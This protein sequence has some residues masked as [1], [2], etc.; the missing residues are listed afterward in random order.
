MEWTLA[1][2]TAL[3]AVTDEKFRKAL[4]II[5]MSFILIL[6]MIPVLVSLP[7]LLISLPQTT[8]QSKAAAD[9]STQDY[10]NVIVEYK[11]KI[12]E[13][14]AD[15][16][17]VYNEKND[18][19][20]NEVKINYPSVAL[21]IAFDNVLNKDRI[22]EKE[23]KIVLD[24][25]KIFSFLD[26]CV[27][28]DIIGTTITSNIKPVEEI[29]R[30][31]FSSDEDINQFMSIYSMVKSTNLDSVVPEVKFSELEYLE[32]GSELPYISQY[33]DRWGD[34]P[35]GD[36]T[37]RESGCGIASMCMV[38]N[39]LVPASN[40][41]PPELANW[42]NSNGF[43]VSGAGTAWAIFPALADKYNLQMRNLSRDNPQEILSELS[44]GH[45]VVVSMSAGHF[46]TGGHFI[47]LCGVTADGK[48]K[49]NDP[50][51]I[52]NSKIE[53]DYSVILTESS[54]LSS[55]CFWSF[56]KK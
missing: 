46:T 18:I 19:K 23:I 43:Y 10:I 37:V 2:K 1:V 47:V 3:K 36:S 30:T 21:V 20:I 12:H 15:Q 55:S 56:S 16:K 44:K 52:K 53:W 4:I 29:A 33:N 39:G 40:I 48:I 34:A 49:V 22:K 45:A 50:A 24:K 11:H 14:L 28:Y 25:D 31:I 27:T 13:K 38:I 42:S 54:V 51:S 5:V 7:V 6:V 32:G 26:S 8:F 35:Y 17:K 9:K 41:L